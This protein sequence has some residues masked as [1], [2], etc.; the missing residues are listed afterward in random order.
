MKEIL[1][2]DTGKEW[3][4]GTNSLIELLK[5]IDKSRYHFTALFYHNYKKSGG[6]DIETELKKLGVDVMLMP[7]YKQPAA[8]KILK[9]LLRATFFWNKGMLRKLVFLID[10]RF[11]I[12]EDANRISVLLK[13]MNADLL[14]MNNQLSS[15]FEG[16]IASDKTGIPAVQHCR[17]EPKLNS[18]E[19]ALA[20]RVVK[21]IIC[22]STGIKESLV[23][24]GVD[25]SKCT[26]VYNGIDAETKPQTAPE[27]IRDE[28]KITTDEILIGTVCSLIRLKRVEDLIK[29]MSIIAHDSSLPIKCVIVGD[30]PERKKLEE[31]MQA[32]NLSDRI[33]FAGFQNDAVSY[34]NVMDIFVLTSEQ[35]G[36]PRSILE[37]MLM[38]KPV[39]ATRVTGTSEVIQNDET[40][41]LVPVS[42]PA[43]I[44][45]AILKLA[46][47]SHLRKS[48]GQKA[49]K[50]AIEEFSAGKYISGVEE[51]F[52]EV[53]GH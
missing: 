49:K 1:I 2:L 50:R 7:Q 39:V 47:D 4:G 14:Y 33:I 17:K 11:R 41:Y 23:S 18:A 52:S 28:L 9:E 6:I 43:A 29:A 16:I 27:R 35:E 3:G 24:Q 5:R 13:N 37:A 20:N 40:G 38:E 26:V 48:M 32:K 10:Y 36:L 21:K 53:L 12:K 51:V 15:N 42:Q 46:N 31:L 45:A 30:G 22:V 19:T 8:A 44:A 34:T 25:A